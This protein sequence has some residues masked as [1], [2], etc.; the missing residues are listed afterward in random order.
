[1]SSNSLFPDDD[2]DFSDWIELY[3]ASSETVSLKSW[4][5]SDDEEDLKKWKFPDR[6]IKAGEYFLIFASDKDKNSKYVHTNFKISSKGETVFLSNKNEELIDKID[7]PKL[8]SDVSYGISITNN[9]KVYFS[10][11]SPGEQNSNIEAIGI[12]ESNIEF[13]HPGGLIN[14]NINITISGNNDD[15]VIRYT[16]DKTVPN[17]NSKIYETPISIEE[18]TILRAKIFKKNYISS[19]DH[20]KTFIHGS[21]HSMNLVTLVTDPVNFFDEDLGIYVYG[22]NAS[23]DWPFHGANFWE[24]WEK[25]IQ[26]S[27]YEKDNKLGIEFNAGV[28]IFGGSSRA[29]DQRSLSIFAR[30]KYGVGEMDYPFFD[31]ISYDKFQAVILRNTGNDWIIAN[32]R[33]AAIS[34]LM[35][36]SDLEFQDFNPVVTYLNGEYWGLY[37]LRE[38]INE[39]MISSKSGYDTDDISILEFDGEEIH[40]SNEDFIDLR[41]FINSEDLSEINNY[42]YVKNQIDIKNFILY[43]LTNIYIGNNDW[44]GNNRKFWKGKNGKWRWI[45]FDTD[46][47]FGLEKG[48][49]YSFNNLKYAT[50]NNCIS[51][52]CRN[53]PWSTV[54]L[55]KLLQNNVFKEQFINHFADEMNSRFLPDNIKSILQSTHDLISSEIDSHYKRWNRNPSRAVTYLNSMKEYADKRPENMKNHILSFFNIPSFNKIT[56]NNNQVE[57]GEILLNDNLRFSENSWFGDYFEDIL[58]SIKAIPKLGYEFSHWSGDV[59]E[60][61]NEIFI[62]PNA[63]KQVTANFIKS[64]LFPLVINEI[65]YKSSKDFDSGDWVEIYNPN[66]KELD[67][68]NW[69]IRDDDDQNIYK[70][71]SNTII[72]SKGFLVVVNNREKFDAL[73]K[74]VNNIIG[75]FDF[76]LGKSD[77]VRLF[78]NY[79]QLV[80]KV[81]YSNKEPWSDCPDASGYTLELINTSLDNL[82]STYWNCNNLYGSPGK[83]NNFPD[84]DNDG[85]VNVLDTCPDSKAGVTVDVTGCELFTL[86]ENNNK[87]S[88]TSSTCIGN[89]DGSIGLSVEDASYSYSVTV[90]GKDD[91]ISLGGETKTASV[92]GLGKGTY[93]VCFTVD[94]QDNYEQCFEVNVGEPEPLSAFID[95]NDDTRETSFQLSGSSSYTIDINGERF[96]VKG[97]NFKTTLST[98]LSVI[99]ITTDLDCQGI[100]EREVF[101]SEDILYYPNPTRGEVDVY[102]HGED[103]KVMM[104]VFSSKGDLIF[105]REQLIQST[106]KTDLDLGGVPAGTYLVTLDGPTVRKTFKI[107][108]K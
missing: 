23:S 74:D 99:T 67:I 86:P 95:V 40:G 14:Q 71:P 1:M 47:A 60:N 62:N 54:Y 94:G 96:D 100:I 63:E 87:V 28:K 48:H 16:T 53:R 82:I 37:F 107:V 10:N 6:Q 7:V 38:K 102:V 11:S 49:D 70:F 35:Q 39:H 65:N 17:I 22:N 76:G 3:N 36:G 18:T 27:Y 101:I 81:K 52:S 108:K 106:R 2:G 58:I 93:T 13:S 32:M 61:S 88:V 98:G 25:P 43:N 50:D 59:N 64:D 31:N 72:D 80:D 103:T 26:F 89:T 78:N 105:S 51:L 84:S 24:D 69:S 30:N 15:E 45:L 21:D 75:D 46:F 12:I 83:D 20:S 29:N 85:I 4:F 33:D 90:T 66:E 44:P 9:N 8:I 34:K 92:T 42:E 79:D 104:T 19:Y 77:S 57:M 68:S 97:N 91:P 56:I 55:R 41:T 5:I 73:H